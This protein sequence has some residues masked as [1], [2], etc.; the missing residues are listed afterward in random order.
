MVEAVSRAEG[1]DLHRA[2]A[3]RPISGGCINEAWAI[4]LESTAGDR[5]RYFVKLNDAACTDPFAAETE[6]LELLRLPGVIRVPRVIARGTTGERA[7]LVLEHIDMGNSGSRR[8]EETLGSQLAMLHK[9]FAT[10]GQFGWTRDNTIG[11]T[12]QVN[13]RTSDWGDFF[14][15]RRLR[16]QFELAERKGY[17]FRRR[18]DFLNQRMPEILAGHHP[19]PSLVHGDLWRGNVGYTSDDQPVIFDPAVYFGDREV[20]IAFTQ[21]FGGFGAGFYRAYEKDWPLPA[22]HKRRA[23]IYNLYHLLNH[24]NLFGGGYHAQAAAAMERIWNVDFRP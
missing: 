21:M 12:L 1:R 6:G 17:D 14:I 20:D 4:E 2:S 15:E 22:G 8:S 19:R 10:D 7:F 11:A 9:T 3:P 18:D 23:D 13:A 5:D 24:L 16:F